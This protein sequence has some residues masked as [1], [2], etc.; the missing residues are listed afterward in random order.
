MN[1]LKQNMAR[2]KIGRVALIFP[3]TDTM[4]PVGLMT[5]GAALERAGTRTIALS[6]YDY[7][8]VDGMPMK[9]ESIRAIEGFAPDMIGVGFLSADAKPAKAAIEYF[10]KA[11]PQSV[12]VA[13]GR[14]ASVFPEAVLGWGADFVVVGEGETAIVELIDALGEGPRRIEALKNVAFLDGEN[15]FRL[16]VDPGYGVD[17]D[18]IPAYHLVPYQRYIDAR[19]AVTGR[20][21]RYGCLITSRGCFSRCSFCRIPGF[22]RPLRFR[23][24]RA[25]EEDILRQLEDYKLDGFYILDDMFAVNEKRVIEFCALFNRIKKER[26]R[27][28]TF[29]ATARAD[30]LTRPMVEA[31]KSA[32]C[33][34]LGIGVESGSQRILDFLETG[35]KITAF[36]PAFEMLQGSGI[37]T[38]INLIAGVPGEEDEDILQTVELLKKIKA[39]TVGVSFLT[40]YP[41]TPFFDLALRKGWIKDGFMDTIAFRHGFGEPQMDLGIPADVLQRRKSMLYG[42]SIKRT[43]FSMLRRAEAVHLAADVMKLFSSRPGEAFRLTRSLASLNIDE[44][45][46]GFRL[47]LMRNAHERPL[48]QCRGLKDKN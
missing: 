15:A 39:S 33:T 22:D 3:V 32:G 36:P 26:Q 12:I 14:H 47:L 21:L 38:F 24:M 27:K 4:P 40:P 20:Y 34:Q 41:G 16:S 35:K 48:P 11:F 23:S 44:F 5:I 42:A 6:L 13:G 29:V 7:K 37:D 10:K 8:H 31:L 46:D 1:E 17:I 28:L 25:I 30:R 19:T 45:K 43:L 18:L 9:P 2:K